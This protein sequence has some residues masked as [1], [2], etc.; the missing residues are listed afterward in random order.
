MD[1]FDHHN[2]SSERKSNNLNG[3]LS[4]NN[5]NN[6]KNQLIAKKPPQRKKNIKNHLFIEIEENDSA[7][8]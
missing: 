1:D 2:H 3:D 4:A 7:K 5:L 6:D 8:E